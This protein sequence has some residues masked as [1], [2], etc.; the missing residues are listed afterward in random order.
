MNKERALCETSD[1]AVR[2]G[3]KKRDA[4]KVATVRPVEDLWW[5][6]WRDVTELDDGPALFANLDKGFYERITD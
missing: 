3:R 5:V 4:G 2:I 6:Q 1:Q